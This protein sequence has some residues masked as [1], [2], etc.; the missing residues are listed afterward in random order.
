MF[1]DSADRL[2]SRAYDA[3]LRMIL[4]DTLLPGTCLS[5]R[6]IATRLDMSRTP[7]REAFLLLENDGL[8]GRLGN[9]RGYY[10]KERRIE[11]FI[12]S[13][14][15]RLILEPEAAARAT[16]RMP[17]PEI[18]M[19]RDRI[20]GLIEAARSGKGVSRDSSRVIDDELHQAIAR[21]T[22]NEHLSDIISTLRRRTAVFDIQSL[23]ERALDSCREHLAILDALENGPADQTR[24]AMRTHLIGVRESIITH[25]TR[26]PRASHA[27]T[28]ML[29]S[30][31][32]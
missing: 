3:L 30:V 26:R 19:F 28:G 13:L 22:A 6:E 25:L 9:N 8:L 12:D 21:A 4:D 20:H 27:E 23:P 5:E 10:I 15:V 32:K 18:T 7:V 29:T 14:E 31:E 24:E 17:L 1:D 11:D 2:S 16:G